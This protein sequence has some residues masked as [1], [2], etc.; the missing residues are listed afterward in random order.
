[1]LKA[2]VSTGLAAIML[3][4]SLFVGWQTMLI[5]TI[6]L[7]AFCEVDGKVKDIAIRVI[8]FF[9]GLTL[10]ITAWGLI[11]DGVELIFS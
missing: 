9:I 10:V 11:V 2:K 4:S 8:T 6:L 7:F 5:V 3:I 1:M